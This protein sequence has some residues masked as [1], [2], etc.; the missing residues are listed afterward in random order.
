[1]ML[2]MHDGELDFELPQLEGRTWTRVA[3][4]ARSSPEDVAEAGAA[5]PVTDAKYW[6]Q[7]RSVVILETDS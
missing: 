2:N 3:D 4:T 6:V 5:A 1:V 7:G